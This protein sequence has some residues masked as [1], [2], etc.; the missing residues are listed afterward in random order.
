MVQSSKF[1]LIFAIVGVAVILQLIFAIA[2]CR[3]TPTK[4]AIEFSKDYFLLNEEMAERLCK[5]LVSDEAN[6]PVKAVIL[7]AAGEASARGFEPGMVKRSLSHIETET[8]SR[9]DK[10]AQIKLNAR[11]RVCI[12]PVFAWVA[13]LFKLGETQEVET[14]ISLIKED[15]GWKVCG[16]PFGLGAAEA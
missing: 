15:G 13:T 1:T 5:E 6:N 16:A 11:S 4:A 7:A 8:I 14:V 3:D 12:N 10:S 2:D 9:D